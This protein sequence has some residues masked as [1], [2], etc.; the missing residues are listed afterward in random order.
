M[1]GSN[2]L[3]SGAVDESGKVRAY[4]Y[5][6]RGEDVSTVVIV[7]NTHEDSSVNVTLALANAAPIKSRR[8]YILTASSLSSKVMQLNGAPIVDT[9]TGQL[10]PLKPAVVT[11]NPTQVTMPAASYAFFELIV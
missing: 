11:S 8:D 7:L 3:A 10:P 2:V 6:G 1:I 4:A 9:G 5:S